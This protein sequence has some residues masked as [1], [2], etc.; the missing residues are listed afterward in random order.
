MGLGL[1]KVRQLAWNA[2]ILTA[3]ILAFAT[4][5]FAQNP[6]ACTSTTAPSSAPP[7]PSIS[8]DSDG[9]LAA[10]ARSS[11]AKTSHAKKVVTDEDMEAAAGPLPRLKMDGPENSDEIVTAIA[12]YKQN[13]TPAQTEE[14]VRLWYERYDEML[15]AAIQDNL[16][17]QTLRNA[18][19]SNGYDLCQESQDYEQCRSRQMAEMRGARNDQLHMMNNST[20]EVRIQHAFQNVRN[21]LWQNN[22][23][24]DWFKIRTT[25]NIDKY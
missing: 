20:L 10:A 14:A 25:N 7:A 21:G 11:K 3:T 24:Y 15:G 1:F 9:S 8:T 23:H 4:L 6:P 18:N 17:V 2:E 5:A 22:L 16:D 19:T 13:H 12:E